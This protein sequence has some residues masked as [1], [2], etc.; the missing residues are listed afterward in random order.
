MTQPNEAGNKKH[1]FTTQGVAQWTVVFPVRFTPTTVNTDELHY[2]FADM[3]SEITN[4]LIVVSKFGV[5]QWREPGR[6][7]RGLLRKLP[8]QNL[9]YPQALKQ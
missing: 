6:D 5:Q 4:V 8:F 1:N 9:E 2:R 3:N 7:D